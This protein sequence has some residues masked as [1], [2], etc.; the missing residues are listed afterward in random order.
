MRLKNRVASTDP[1][2]QCVQPFTHSLALTRTAAAVRLNEECV[3]RKGTQNRTSCTP[4]IKTST[5][6]SAHS[7]GSLL[8]WVFIH[9]LKI[10]PAFR[11]KKLCCV[12][13][14]SFSWLSRRH[15]ITD[16]VFAL[17][18]F[19]PQK[20]RKL[21]ELSLS[22]TKLAVLCSKLR[23]TQIKITMRLLG[24]FSHK[25][26]Q[27]SNTRSFDLFLLDWTPSAR[28]PFQQS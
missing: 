16:S 11:A 12:Y 9:C 14:I 18:V 17:P 2:G 21:P 20:H 7:V 24:W 23:N 28:L 8:H 5:R 4:R 10:A 25:K 27:K 15:R 3:A 1:T 13:L 6:R 22:S 26:P 19:F